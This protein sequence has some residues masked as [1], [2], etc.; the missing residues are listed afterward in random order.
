VDIVAY[1]ILAIFTSSRQRC[2]DVQRAFFMP[3]SHAPGWM[4]TKLSIV[5]KTTTY[6]RNVMFSYPS[7]ADDWRK[8]SC[9]WHE[10]LWL[11]GGT[12]VIAA[13]I[14][15]WS[16]VHANSRQLAR[17]DVCFGWS[18]DVFLVC[19]DI[20]SSELVK[21]LFKHKRWFKNLDSTIKS[22]LNQFYNKYNQVY[23]Y[24]RV[25]LFTILYFFYLSP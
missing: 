15:S 21:W 16:H 12:Y 2:V 22:I 23:K 20:Y 7:P 24:V 19:K 8:L 1:L 11:A 9:L 17:D 25:R 18:G 5:G 3:R 6:S 10:R 13:T 4:R 14:L